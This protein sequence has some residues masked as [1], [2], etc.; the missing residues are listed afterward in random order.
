MSATVKSRLG[1]ALREA[2]Q[3]RGWTLADLSKR[4]GFSISS[5][6]KVE[7]DQLSFSYDKLIRLSEGLGTDV[8]QLFAPP[9]SAIPPGALTTR[10]S[11][12]RYGEGELVTTS[13][14]D[15]RYL[16]T[17]VTHKKLIPILVDLRARTLAEFGELVRHSGEEFVYVLAGEIEV[18]TEHYAPILLAAGESAYLDSTM[19]HGYLAK[20][21]GPW[22]MLAICSGSDS[23]IRAVTGNAP[24]EDT[25]SRK[26]APVRRRATA[27]P[28]QPAA[29]GAQRRGK[30]SG[31]R[32][33]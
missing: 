8:S 26:L 7:N 5:L 21:N 14:Y 9:Q 4:T 24:S 10:R 19:R 3:Q 17:D 16:S 31:G 32:A 13:N 22:R 29:R 23:D 25:A 33:P 2:R 1:E 6:S 20:G 27:A 11:V 18:H 12:N 30:K 28:R 15:Y